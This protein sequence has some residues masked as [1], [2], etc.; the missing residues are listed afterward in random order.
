MCRTWQH[1]MIIIYTANEHAQFC[2]VAKSIHWSI[3]SIFFFQGIKP[4]VVS[5]Y[6]S[7][8]VSLMV[9]SHLS[10]LMVK[11][12]LHSQCK[13]VANSLMWWFQSLEKAPTSLYIWPHNIIWIHVIWILTMWTHVINSIQK[14]WMHS[15][16]NWSYRREILPMWQELTLPLTHG[17]FIIVKSYFVMTI[18]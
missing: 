8:S 14:L 9:H 4:C 3:P 5:H 12:F 18:S 2:G 15:A 11:P 10:G 16:G 6:T 13:M 1:V 17:V 7:Q